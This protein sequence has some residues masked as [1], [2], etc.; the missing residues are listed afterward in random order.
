MTKEDQLQFKKEFKSIVYQYS[1]IQSSNNRLKQLH[2]W[3]KNGSHENAIIKELEKKK[4]IQVKFKEM[5]KG[6]DYEEWKAMSKKISTINA[7][8]SAAISK[9]EKAERDLNNLF[10]QL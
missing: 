4:E 10:F 2:A 9:K 1:E 7:K 5:L 6:M 3:D 8:I